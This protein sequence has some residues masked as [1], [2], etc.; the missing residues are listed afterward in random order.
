MCVFSFFVFV[1][2]TAASAVTIRPLGSPRLSQF[3]W[4][5]DMSLDEYAYSSDTPLVNR[6]TPNKA[7]KQQFPSHIYEIESPTNSSRNNLP[8]R[9]YND[10]RCPAFPDRVFVGTKLPEDAPQLDVLAYDSLSI[11]EISKSDH[12]L[13]YQVIQFPMYVVSS[14]SL[15]SSLSIILS[16]ITITVINTQ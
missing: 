12:D 5:S 1:L 4:G 9:P 14:C 11:G 13:V 10:K 3:A 15:P 2:S 7:A 16:Q 6:R 8:I